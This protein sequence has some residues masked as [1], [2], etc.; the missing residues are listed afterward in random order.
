MRCGGQW[1]RWSG[2]IGRLKVRM[3]RCRSAIDFDRPEW[4]HRSRER[5]LGVK[6]P[7]ESGTFDEQ[8]GLN[9][10][11]VVRENGAKRALG[12]AQP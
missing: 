11:R 3:E 9:P 8:A 5:H 4:G 1:E 10:V 6:H 12:E 2:Y 7:H